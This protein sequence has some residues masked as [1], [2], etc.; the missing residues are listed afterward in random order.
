MADPAY[1]FVDYTGEGSQFPGVR[2]RLERIA[3][4]AGYTRDRLALIADR[5]HR[6]RFEIFRYAPKAP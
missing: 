2:Q 3:E 5:N 1:A 4:D 6:P